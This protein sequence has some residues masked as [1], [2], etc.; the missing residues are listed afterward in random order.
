MP[1]AVSPMLAMAVTFPTGRSVDD[2]ILVSANSITP[3]PAKRKE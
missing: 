3:A 1:V 2:M